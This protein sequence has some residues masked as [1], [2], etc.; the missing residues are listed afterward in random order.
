MLPP[1]L[2]MMWASASFSPRVGVE[3]GVSIQVRTASLRS[4]RGVSLRNSWVRA[5]T[6]LA[7]R[8]SSMT[9]MDLQLG[10]DGLG[11]VVETGEALE[12]LADFAVAADE[13]ASGISEPGAE[14]VGDF[15]AAV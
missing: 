8:T 9:V 2:R 13:E 3:R 5:Y 11:D 7:A 12:F 10:F 6:S 4:G 1:V 14:L 15:L